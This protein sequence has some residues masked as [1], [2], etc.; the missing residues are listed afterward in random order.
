MLGNN[1][2]TAFSLLLCRIGKRK[3]G[4]EGRKGG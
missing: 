1:I 3:K 2:N 4:G